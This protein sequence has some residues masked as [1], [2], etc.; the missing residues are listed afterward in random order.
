MAINTD[1]LKIK[2][3]IDNEK[4][5]KAIKETNKNIK[6]LSTVVNI[7]EESFKNLSIQIGQI[8]NV[9]KQ[10]TILNDALA[11]SYDE[12]AKSAI[13]SA[14]EMRNQIDIMRDLKDI[15]ASTASFVTT[16]VKASFLGAAAGFVS[17]KTG[18]SDM[19][20]ETKAFK[21][22][23]HDVKQLLGVG[24]IFEQSFKDIKN[25][26]YRKSL[27]SFTN[28]MKNTSKALSIFSIG[29]ILAAE[30]LSFLAKGLVGFGFAL[31]SSEN[32][33]VSLIGKITIFIGILTGGFSVALF[34]VISIVGE[35]AISLGDSLSKGMNKAVEAF[36]KGYDSIRKFGL[37]TQNVLNEQLESG[38]ISNVTE[39]LGRYT[40]AIEKAAR[41]TIFSGDAIRDSLKLIIAESRMFGFT[42]EE[43][44]KIFNRATEIA[45]ATGKELQD[46]TLRII[47]G[48]AGSS[49]G[50]LALG[51]N[52]K[53]TH[54]ELKNFQEMQGQ[55]LQSFSEQ[56]KAMFR[57]NDL[58]GQSKIFL[59]ANAIAMDSFT[60][61][62][63]R[64]EKAISDV[65]AK[66]GQQGEIILFLKGL[67]AGFLEMIA[68]LPDFFFEVS[69]AVA[70]VGAV[71]LKVVGVF[72]KYAA[73]ILLLKASYSGLSFAVSS[74]IV[75]QTVLNKVFAF[76]AAKAG[77]A[78]LPV[79]SLKIAFINLGRILKAVVIKDLALLNA[80]LIA[81]TKSALA[82]F[83]ALLKNPFTWLAI[84]VVMLTKAMIDLNRETKILDEFFNIFSGSTEEVNNQLEKQAEEVGFLTK[85][86]TFLKDVFKSVVVVILNAISVIIGLFAEI[87]KSIPFLGDSIVK[88][89][90]SVSTKAAAFSKKMEDLRAEINENLGSGVATAA[91]RG[92][93]AVDKL[94]KKFK[95]LGLTSEELTK[96]IKE[97]AD[98]SKDIA[99]QSFELGLTSSFDDSELGRLKAMIKLK[100]EELKIEE[101]KI[102]YSGIPMANVTLKPDEVNKGIEELRKLR[103]EYEKL[104]KLQRVRIIKTNIKTD[105]TQSKMLLDAQKDVEDTLKN[106]LQIQNQITKSRLGTFDVVRMEFKE[107]R[108]IV[109]EQI[110]QLKLENDI[111]KANRD[112]LIALGASKKEI[113][114]VNDLLEKRKDLIS[115]KESQK[116]IL[117]SQQQTEIE[118]IGISIGTNLVNA[119]K[120]GADALVGTA[121]SEIGKAIGP[122]GTLVAESIN[123]LRQGYEAMFELGRDFFKILA[124]LPK[125]I[126][127][128]IQGLIEG[129]IQGVLD[130]LTDPELLSSIYSS[131][132]TLFP[133]LLTAAFKALP[134]LIKSLLNLNFWMEVLESFV[135]AIIQS[136]VE[137][138]HTFLDMLTGDLPDAIGKAFSDGIKAVPDTLMGFAQDMFSV[139]EDSAIG[140]MGG[141]KDSSLVEQAAEA[142][143]TIWERFIEFLVKGWHFFLDAGEAIWL[144]FRDGLVGLG[145]FLVEAGKEF[146]DF[147]MTIPKALWDSIVYF[148]EKFPGQ[149]FEGLMDFGEKMWILFRDAFSS[150]GGFFLDAFKGIAGGLW[151][152]FK[153]AFSGI[154]NFFSNIFGDLWDGFKDGI[155]NLFSFPESKG[156]VEG[157]MGVDLPVLK[158]A[159]G[160]VVPGIAPVRGDSPKN[161]NQ[162]SM[163]SPGEWVIPRSI[164][165]DKEKA[166]QLQQVI[167]GD[168]PQFF[169]GAI[170][171]AGEVTGVSKAISDVGE[172]TGVNSIL[173]EAENAFKG[174]STTLKAV[175]N[176]VSDN[177]G[178]VD[179]VKFVENPVK[180]VMKMIENGMA[181]FVEPRASG[182]I[183]SLAQKSF[184]SGGFVGNNGM[185]NLQ[186]GEFVMR[187]SAVNNI[188]LQNL[189]G[190]NAGSSMAGSNQEFNI[191]ITLNTTEKVDES[192]LTNR[193]MPEFK[194]QLKDASLRGDFVISQKG[195]R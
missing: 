114:E 127:E 130:L 51:I 62:N 1:E 112:R 47:Q 43:N 64:A 53:D 108:N 153:D 102:K 162:L 142:G 86:W 9:T 75:V 191:D 185:A 2:V 88:Y 79:T 83:A 73:V 96:K 129:L 189:M 179:I 144:A 74:L 157:W 27:A 76:T 45:S 116:D 159:E 192:F 7:N 82:L 103:E 17:Y 16:V 40:D 106:N 41:A 124:N 23:S 55:S 90:D 48:L 110:N 42:S 172:A 171:K 160:G 121:I 32:A 190:M 94:D 135:D 35:L 177:I 111:I 38:L 36:Q 193:L 29:S 100:E 173:E 166:T 12:V 87:L 13:N 134:K 59:G 6:D 5:S 65:I 137:A 34:Y 50:L 181:G 184:H 81:T 163:L 93:E 63:I 10:G 31:S 14:D 174:L 77:V 98:L 154:G 149:L 104:F 58:M 158:F 140:M 91:E 109:D 20:K 146:F 175:Y 132:V 119:A 11:G 122:I 15:L 164:T 180:A 170:R 39:E 84:Y 186:G 136:F 8:Q 61:A 71:L 194:Q 178:A 89:L 168:V 133:K 139:V 120:S 118:N 165:Q 54:V 155:S 126:T 152:A 80:W 141:G 37:I 52:L 123:L 33:L 46:V 125:M 147:I 72:L 69:G 145:D 151:Q 188:G 18:F 30:R 99:K 21:V 24:N 138:W 169:M 128:G 143:K 187:K 161:D 182:I 19:I 113:Q 117:S 148:I 57:L 97:W 25:G 131:I 101:E 22:V 85:S 183:K 44:I 95:K 68:E 70:D 150:L 195:I 66:L 56:E 167:S 3:V 92:S 60:G 26:E 115:A 105:F 78:V 49:Q 156:T 107:K 4:A 176:W 28:Q 67:Y